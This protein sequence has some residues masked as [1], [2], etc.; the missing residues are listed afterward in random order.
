MVDDWLDQGRLIAPFGAAD[1]T[2]AAF[3]LCR[4]MGLAPT[5]AAR[6]FTGWAI[7]I[8]AVALA[9]RLAHLWQLRA[10]PFLEVTLGDSATYDAWARSLAA[11]NWLGDE[12]FFQ[13]PLY[14]YF[15]GALYATLGDGQLLVRG[16]QCVLSALGCALVAQ[17]G[18][19]LFSRG[20]G[21]AAGLLLA[22]YAPSIFLDALLQKSVLDLLF[23][24]LAL[25]TGVPHLKVETHFLHSL[26]G[27]VPFRQAVEHVD[28]RLGGSNAIELMIDTKTP[29]G[30]YEPLCDW[31]REWYETGLAAYVSLSEHRP[32]FIENLDRPELCAKGGP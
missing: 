10:S 21:I 29:G 28:E 27:D 32:E 15:L 16:V 5:A 22:T 13:A 25:S 19:L 8:F 1:P 23:V 3:Y 31:I 2:G 11:G 24:A 30:V 18:A 12:V 6:P 17:A 4:P 9:L 7:G 14:P 26:R 20:A